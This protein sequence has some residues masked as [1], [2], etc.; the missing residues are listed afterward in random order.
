[1]SPQKRPP[2]SG[3]LGKALEVLRCF[4]DR[5]EQ[6]GVRELAEKLGLPSSTTHRLLRN[7]ALEGYLRFDQDTRKYSVGLEMYRIGAVLGERLQ[8]RDIARERMSEL[9][10][11][12]A[13]PVWLALY[14][15]SNSS[16]VVVAQSGG[17]EFAGTTAPL[18][19]RLPLMTSAEGKAVLAFLGD[20]STPNRASSRPARRADTPEPGLSEVRARGYAISRSDGA[21]VVSAPILDGQER[22]IASLATRIVNDTDPATLQL[23]EAARAV[24]QAL[25]SRLLGGGLAGTW[26]VGIRAIADLVSRHVPGVVMT[27]ES[28]AG[29]RNLD[30]LE[31]G[32]ANYC[33]A[34]SASVDAAYEGRP[35]FTTP[36]KRLAVMFSVFP[37]YLHIVLR[38]GLDVSRL[39]DLAGLRISPA[40]RGFTTAALFDQ[41]MALAG[42]KSTQLARA[43]TKI[44]HLDYAEANRQLQEG[45]LD[46]VVSLSGIPNPAYVEVARSSPIGLLGIEKKI[47]TGLTANRQ[48]YSSGII[49]GGTYPG[50]TSDTPTIQIPTVMTT[51]I[52][53]AEDEVYEI[54]RAVFERKAD[55]VRQIPVFEQFGPKFVLHG[56]RT[57]L[58]PGA[59]RY[60]RERGLM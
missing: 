57:P 49:P 1:M 52:D 58:H 42:F 21:L 3:S 32:F 30:N 11:T 29:D 22:P 35:P 50:I 9:S 37:L 51:V 56:F 40:D 17:R 19:A 33:L 60:W 41:L 43:G 10:K 16:M 54:T 20:G 48:G 24:S 31:R 27:A 5:Q 39:S 2:D 45:H 59:R 55:L 25:G 34:V 46:V 28:G 8:I 12:L 15:N 7:L 13:Q 23:C 4:V 38:A 53:R 14:D 26:H 44:F 47:V 6:W 36:H 18:G